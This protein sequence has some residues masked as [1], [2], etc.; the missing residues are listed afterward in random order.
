M[1]WFEAFILGLV[2]GLTEFLPVSSSGH[3]QI[4]ELLF[5]TQAESNLTFTVLVHGGT[6]LS[7]LVVFRKDIA[8]LIT[9]FFRFEWNEST[10]YVVKILVSM[11]PVIVVGLFFESAVEKLF[12]TGGLFVGS[13]LMVTGLLLFFTHFTKDKGREISYGHAFII[14]VAQA[15]AVVPGISRSGAT[16]ATGMFLGNKRSELA[17]FSFLM[18]IIPVIGVN[19]KDIMDYTGSTHAAS[20]HPAILVTGFITAFLTGLLACSAM[21]KLVSKGRL[22]YFGIYCLIAGLATVLFL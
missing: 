4:G 7:V 6:V 14:G 9:G 10:Q 17:R 19:V 22:I 21:V 1:N 11:I 2:Q 16:I 8:Q 13:M 5:H 12:G 3:L 20:V 15:I 18:M